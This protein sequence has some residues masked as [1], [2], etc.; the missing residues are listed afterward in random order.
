MI[1]PEEKIKILEEEILRNSVRNPGL[2]VLLSFF[3]PGLGQIYNGKISK[4]L[5]FIFSHLLL[6]F[7]GYQLFFNVN[8]EINIFFADLSILPFV[9]IIYLIVHFLF[10]FTT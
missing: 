4:G 9:K 10:F 3:L 2:A 7:F 6:L 5:L 8:G 1:S